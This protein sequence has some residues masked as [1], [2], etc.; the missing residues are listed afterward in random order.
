VGVGCAGVGVVAR[1]ISPRRFNRGLSNVHIQSHVL[2][3]SWHRLPQATIPANRLLIHNAKEGWAPLCTFLELAPC[4]TTDYPRSNSGSTF[5]AAVDVLELI[6]WTWPLALVVVLLCIGA[7]A[8]RCRSTL[9]L[10]K[11]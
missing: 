5:G 6:T 9:K 3:H 7:A 4:P 10:K 11:S 1:S 8:L 2:T